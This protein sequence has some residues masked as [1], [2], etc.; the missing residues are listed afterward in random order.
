MRSIVRNVSGIRHLFRCLLLLFS[1]FLSRCV[2]TEPLVE[3]DFV[4]KEVFGFSRDTYQSWI[5]VL[6]QPDSAGL[7]SRKE[8][9]AF[10]ELELKPQLNLLHPPG[11]AESCLTRALLSVLS[12]NNQCQTSAKTATKTRAAAELLKAFHESRRRRGGKPWLKSIG[13]GVVCNRRNGI[14]KKSLVGYYWGEL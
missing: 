5:E 4:I 14:P 10:I 8:A 12:K 6:V 9:V 13:Q 1:C 7:Q 2:H 3:S 11:D